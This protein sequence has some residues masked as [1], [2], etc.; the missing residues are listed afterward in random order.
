V[1]SGCPDSLSCDMSNACHNSYHDSCVLGGGDPE[2][3][4][5]QLCSQNVTS[6]DVQQF[7][8]SGNMSS[9]TSVIGYSFRPLSD[10]LLWT[11]FS[12]QSRMLAKAIEY[13]GCTAEGKLWLEQED[14]SF[15]CSMAPY[16]KAGSGV[17][18]PI[19][20]WYVG[21][22]QGKGVQACYE[23]VISDSRCAKDYFTYVDGGDENCGCK[24]QTG[25][26]TV[27]DDG[28]LSTYYS[29]QDSAIAEF[30]VL[31]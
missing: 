30:L 20:L 16:V 12:N 2:I 17:A 11:G 5:T 18:G 6:E 10:V 29:I 13:H 3:L 21:G 31:P 19:E 28:G 9:R 15:A 22:A 8:N 4:A 24:G 14:G 7:L 26:L 25:A 1:L 23:A 27:R